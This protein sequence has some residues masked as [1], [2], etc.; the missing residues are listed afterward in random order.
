MDDLKPLFEAGATR[1]E[2]LLPEFVKPFYGSAVTNGQAALAGLK[3]ERGHG[4]GRS[5]DPRA[6]G[7]TNSLGSR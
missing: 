4:S 3:D 7:S 6:G 1:N 5:P 2:R